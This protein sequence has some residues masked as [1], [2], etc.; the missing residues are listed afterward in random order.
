MVV[1]FTAQQAPAQ[2][3]TAGRVAGTSLSSALG[4]GTVPCH[5]NAPDGPIGPIAFTVSCFPSE[6]ISHVFDRK[7]LGRAPSNWIVGHGL[8]FPQ[9][10]FDTV[11]EWLE[12]APV[13]V[14]ARSGRSNIQLTELRDILNGRNT[15]KLY[16]HGG[17]L[18]RRKF[19]ALARQLDVTFKGKGPKNV[20]IL[21][22]YHKLAASLLRD[23]Q[24][25]AIGLRALPPKGLKV[26]SVD[27]H[28]PHDATTAASYPLSLR[29]YLGKRRG[30]GSDQVRL[31]YI[32]R[33]ADRYCN[34]WKN[35]L[36]K[37]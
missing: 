30:T 25:V 2:G 19:D 15:T 17:D 18:H 4:W 34:D 5:P 7:M 6:A 26:V 27:K 14:S 32:K 3:R 35:Q 24:A 10:K 29:M 33:M 9:D 12:V 37:K 8:D 13:F 11:A 36:F 16:L 1:L 23:T 31:A 21:R 20:A 28:F 22:D